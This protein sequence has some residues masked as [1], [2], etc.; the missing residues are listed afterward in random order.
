MIEKLIQGCHFSGF[1]WL[2]G[3]FIQKKRDS[4][5]AG[6]LSYGSLNQVKES[7][8]F[9]LASLTKPLVTGKLYKDLYL[10]HGSHFLEQDL[11]QFS[12]GK[13]ES[14]LKI[15]ELLCHKTGLINW[16]PFYKDYKKEEIKALRKDPI[17]LGEFIQLLTDKAKDPENPDKNYVYSDL[18]F[19]IL[20][21][22][23]LIHTGKSLKSDFTNYGLAK[24]LFFFDSPPDREVCGT[25]F[26]FQRRKQLFAEVE[27]ENAGYLGHFLSGHAGLFSSAQSLEFALKDWF[28]FFNSKNSSGFMDENGQP[29]SFDKSDVGGAVYNVLGSENV[30]GHHG[31]SGTSFWLNIKNGDYLIFLS[32]RNCI[33]SLEKKFSITRKECIDYL[34]KRFNSESS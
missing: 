34:W 12:K 33:I 6:K 9:D 13:I 1:Q 18:N 2:S 5:F 23:Y 7:T 11:R 22:A 24:E 19:I 27:D 31:F 16:L 25:H 8:L 32:N 4:S 15:S 26:S 29:Y 20:A 10:K 17:K 3:N 28:D 21:G 14:T 30:F